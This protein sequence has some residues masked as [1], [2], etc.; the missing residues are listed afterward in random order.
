MR[1]NIYTLLL[2]VLLL[3]GL[4]A[5]AQHQLYQSGQLFVQFDNECSFDWQ[6][7]NIQRTREL[8]NDFPDLLQLLQTF[9]ATELKRAFTLPNPRLQHIYV[10]HYEQDQLLKDELLQELNQLNYVRYAE[11]VPLY[12][13]FDCTPNDPLFAQQWSMTNTNMPAALELFL[14]GNT[15]NFNNVPICNEGVVLAMVDDAVLTT[16]EDIAPMLWVNPGEIAGNGIDDDANGYI[17]DIN[18]WDVAFNDN[19]PYPDVLTDTHGTHCAGIAAGST[20]N[21]IGVASPAGSIVQLM[22]VKTAS[23]GSLVAPYQGVQYAMASG[24]DVISMSWGGGGF[25]QTYQTL[26]DVAYSMGIVCVAAA[27]NDHVDIPMYPASYDHVIS[28]AATDNADQLAIFSNFGTTIDIAAPGVDIMSCLADNNSAYGQMSGTSMAC[29]FVSSVCALMLYL[30]PALTPDAV[31]S[32]LQNTATDVS[33]LNPD[34]VGMMGAG[35]VNVQGVFQCLENVPIVGFSYQYDVYCPGQ[36]IA[37]TDE[38]VSCQISAWQWSFPGGTPASSNVPNPTVSFP[39]GTYNIS[40]TVTNVYG[41]STLS[42]TVLVGSP[43]VTLGGGGNIVEGSMLSLQLTYNG[44]LP[45]DVTY[46]DGTDTYNIS[47][48]NENP[49][50]FSV[51]PSDTTTYT[52]LSA[53]NAFC[54]ANISGE[55]VVNVLLVSGN[56][57]ICKFGNVYGNA[58]DNG[59]NRLTSYNPVTE[60]VHI[61]TGDPHLTV[62]NTASGD[63]VT[64]KTYTGL[65]WP[66]INYANTP[67]GDLIGI[68]S[69]TWGP[70]S[71]WYANRIDAAGNLIWAVR[72]EGAGRQQVPNIIPSIGD[73]YFIAGW[74]NNYGGSSDDF[75]VIKIDGSGNVIASVALNKGDDQM[76]Q[77]TPDGM[78]GLYMIGEV[79]H[80]YTVTFVHLDQNLAV[81]QTH[82][83]I[84]NVLYYNEGRSVIPTSDG[85]YALTIYQN[86]SGTSQYGVLMKIDAAYNIQWV[87][88]F[89]PAVAYTTCYPNDLLEDSSGNIYVSGDIFLSGTNYRAFFAKFSSAGTLLASKVIANAGGTPINGR[90]GAIQ[91][92][93]NS[94]FAPMIL[95]AYIPG[96]PFGQHDFCIVRTTEDLDECMLADFALTVIDDGWS[97]LPLTMADAPISL[98]AQPLTGTT[99]DETI[100]RQSDCL[101]CVVSNCTLACSFTVPATDIC[102]GSSVLLSADCSGTSYLWFVNDNVVSTDSSFTHSFGSPGIYDIQLFVN[103]D[104]CTVMAEGSI[105]VVS[106]SGDAGPDLIICPDEQG[107]LLASG[108][109]AYNWWPTAE[110][111]DPNIANPIVTPTI[112]ATYYVA[113]T[114]ALGCVVMDSVDVWL[115]PPPVLLPLQLDTTICQND[116]LVYQI[117]NGSPISDYTYAWSPPTGLSCTDCPNPTATTNSSIVYT[118]TVS[119]S[120]GCSAAQTFTVNIDN[121]LVTTDTLFQTTCLLLEVGYFTDT[122]ANQYGCDSIVNRLVSLLPSNADTIYQTTCLPDEEGVQ[123]LTV[124]N[125]YGCDSTTTIIT[126][127][128]PSSETTLNLLTCEEDLLGTV[129]ETLVA[130]NGCDSTVISITTLD[131]DCPEYK[132][133]M[134]NAFSP[135]QDGINDVFFVRSPDMATLYIAVYNRWG[136]KVFETENITGTWDGRFKD[137]DCEIGVYVYF[138]SGTFTNGEPFANKGNITLIR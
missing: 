62:I 18:G 27:G 132:V 47:G 15:C 80:D 71:K 127:L 92:N 109:I 54:S 136:Q 13:L 79:E 70:N 30:N 49:Y 20:N 94:A 93:P 22:A 14:N 129:T 133:V 137:K 126:E 5:L 36:P 21:G 90:Y 23:F 103:N 37:L 102:S 89:S 55:A 3:T 63:V 134:P 82:Q 74:Y 8:G 73:T 97:Y 64:A 116:T 67:N 72:Y 105:N 98:I 65:D 117:W 106:A 38:S 53:N 50:F 81:L 41:S 56:E 88:R 135:N 59:L 25:S 39:A 16:H 40:L 11:R 46:T 84:P 34:Y 6:H 104:T 99:T 24:A 9:R 51:T 76:G 78:G 60:T 86:T 52:L 10:L 33:A 44:S 17:D 77:I 120:F 125:Q 83:Y 114:N 128:L 31:L 122:L 43:T 124:P 75:G 12:H 101:D 4:P 2:F 35:V 107:Q 48:I 96:G 68:R 111:N 26:F 108:G 1:H 100:N 131:P 32:C 95:G 115:A 19:N 29:P 118:L 113:I 61:G 45:Y 28:V 130:V 85:G 7:D 66:G 58:G 42:Q 57:Q 119:N 121:P 112:S 87:K 69:D 91:Y 110:L 123:I 138:T